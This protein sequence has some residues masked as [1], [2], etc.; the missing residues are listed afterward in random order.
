M[1]RTPQGWRP[2][3]APRVRWELAHGPIPD[4]LWV[5]H[6]C[7]RPVCVRLEHLWLGTRSDN[8]RDMYAKGRGGGRYGPRV[9]GRWSSKH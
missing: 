1:M 4:G 2:I 5:L 9:R 6:T 8:M 7:D 3:K